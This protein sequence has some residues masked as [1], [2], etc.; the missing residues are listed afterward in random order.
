MKKLAEFPSVQYISIDTASERR[1]WLL[2]QFNKNEIKNTTPHIFK[3]YTL[4]NY[5]VTGK[6][7]HIPP[8]DFIGPVTSHLLT[9][10]SWYENTSEPYTIICED[11]VSFETVKFWNFT[12]IDFFNKLPQDWECIQLSCIYEFPIPVNKDITFK[13]RE[14]FDWGCQ[15]YLI[16]RSYAKKLI[17]TFFDNETFVLDIPNSDYLPIAEHILFNSVDKN[18]Y[19]LPLFVENAELISS[20]RDVP[21][22]LNTNHLESYNFVL[23]WWEEVGQFLNLNEIFDIKIR[24]TLN[25]CFISNNE[26]EFWEKDYILNTLLP[27]RFNKRIH[28]FSLDNINI[29]NSVDVFVFNCREVLYESVF[30]VVKKIKPKIII[31]LSDEYIF[32]NKDIF[33]NLGNYCK[34]FI[35]NYTYSTYTYTP[36]TLI[37]PLGYTN[38]VG[39]Q[40]IQIPLIKERNLN[41]AFVG[42][43]KNDRRHMVDTFTEIENNLITSNCSKQQ[44]QNVYLNTIFAPCGR[45]NSNLECFRLY[46]ASMLGAIPVVVGNDIEIKNTFSYFNNKPPWVFANTWEEAKDICQNLLQ[47]K[48]K[49]QQIQTKNL[50]WWQKTTDSIKSNIEDALKMVH[51]KHIYQE[52]Q[53]GENWFGYGNLY[54]SMVKRFQTNSKFVEVGSWKGKSSA[55]MAVEIANSNKHIDFYCVDTWKGSIEHQN[56]PDIKNLYETF[57]HN[58]EPLKGYFNPIR[59][60]SIEAAKDFKD[61]SL[62]FVFIDASHEYEDVKNDI[63]AWLPKVKNGGILAGHDYYD[64]QG[65]SKA[66]QELLTNFK[67]IDYCWVYEVKKENNIFKRF[68]EDTESP[69]SNFELGLYYYNL[70]HTA[71]AQTHFLRC[72]ERTNDLKLAYE[73]LILCYYCYDKQGRRKF[74]A[75]HLLLQALLIQPK[76]PEAYFLLARYYERHNDWYKCYTYATLGLKLA[77][78]TSPGLQTDIEYPGKYGLL[79]EKAIAAWYWEKID[80]SKEILTDLKNNHAI[81]DIYRASIEHNLA[82]L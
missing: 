57:L 80:E 8:K 21:G 50:D 65:V 76:R 16:N 81:N 75:E 59:K 71:S 44:L 34:L 12:W 72:S 19:N 31:C 82:K 48:T 23:Q 43:F 41:W 20:M 53:F 77:D 15:I 70:G 64:F 11:D 22:K 61:N 58:M 46:E 9:I 5:Q 66:V 7:I 28:N 29:P 42:N 27:R 26:N 10:K 30:E 73:S 3:H 2:N 60:S 54:S 13:L 36:N 4:C 78:F 18:V 69:E 37:I 67:I 25:I 32:E 35:R 24:P 74:T 17:E 40:N 51:M 39:I 55:F 62:D 52:S 1:D 14:P 38:N 45:G 79:Y 68:C 6:K 56:N 47:D 49:I 33:N 63:K